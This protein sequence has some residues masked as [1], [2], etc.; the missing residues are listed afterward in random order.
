MP[1]IPP[2]DLSGKVTIITGGRRGIGLA[3]ARAFAAAGAKVI[4][5]GAFPCRAWASIR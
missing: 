3:I 4:V 1:Q 2:F 5:A